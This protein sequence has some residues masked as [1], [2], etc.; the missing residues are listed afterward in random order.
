LTD[1]IKAKIFGLTSAKLYGVDPITG[2][3]SFDRSE[4]VDTQLT[5][6]GNATYGPRTAAQVQRIQQ[7]DLATIHGLL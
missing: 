7:T 2:T 6:F 4:I 5:S 1:D 3:C